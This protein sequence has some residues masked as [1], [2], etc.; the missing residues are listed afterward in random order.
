MGYSLIQCPPP[1]PLDIAG[2]RLGY[3]EMCGIAWIAVNFGLYVIVMI[4]QLGQLTRNEPPAGK[5]R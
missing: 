4:G 1:V 2:M 5:D 3:G